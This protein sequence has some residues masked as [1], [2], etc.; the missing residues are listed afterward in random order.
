M[1]EWFSLSDSSQ[2][3]K[4]FADKFSRW[5]EEVRGIEAAVK[6]K[7]CKT[8]FAKIKKLTSMSSNNP[9]IKS[10]IHDDFVEA[11]PDRVNHLAKNYFGSI[12]GTDDIER[13]IKEVGFSKALG[14]DL[15][16]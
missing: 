13:A 4:Q 7:D 15:F 10:I 11:D 8:A 14:P 16:D 9:I 2:E 1:P 12:F 5:R 6:M 3:Q